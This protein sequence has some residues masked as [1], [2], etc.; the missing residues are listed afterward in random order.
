MPCIRTKLLNIEATA[1]GKWA[2]TFSS[3]DLIIG[4]Y[5]WG[6]SGSGPAYITPG[7]TEDKRHRYRA[8]LW[9]TGSKIVGLSAARHARQGATREVYRIAFSFTSKATV[10]YNVDGC[11]TIDVR[12]VLDDRL[13]AGM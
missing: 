4:D 6:L 5:L 7:W 13:R 11:V 10:T 12:R 3:R 1:V 9:L 8:T 2:A